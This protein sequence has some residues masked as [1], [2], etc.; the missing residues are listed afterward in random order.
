MNYF[1]PQDSHLKTG[2]DR[3]PERHGEEDAHAP[4]RVER[5]LRPRIENGRIFLAE[6]PLYLSLTAEGSSRNWEGLVRLDDLGFCC[7]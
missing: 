3:L 7:N 2:A 4:D 6:A 1:Y 5:I